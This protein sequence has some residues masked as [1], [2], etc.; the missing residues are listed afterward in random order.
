MGDET[1][2]SSQFSPILTLRLTHT[3]EGSFDQELQQY[4][5]HCRS[6][7]AVWVSFYK[8]FIGRFKKGKCVVQ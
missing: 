5:N 6:V 3:N 2:I 8:I 4:N 7:C 1:K